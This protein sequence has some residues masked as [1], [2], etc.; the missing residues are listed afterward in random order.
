MT[1][2]K[3]FVI[4]HD[5]YLRGL[6]SQGTIACIKRRSERVNAKLLTNMG[7]FTNPNYN[8]LAGSDVELIFTTIA[9]F[10]SKLADFSCSI[11]AYLVMTS[12]FLKNLRNGQRS[13]L[14]N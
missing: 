12:Y 3:R 13:T 7:R 2:I 9:V 4:K 6:T 10:L 1:L 8:F 11:I 14:K 5:A